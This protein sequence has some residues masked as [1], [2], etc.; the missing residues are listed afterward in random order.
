MDDDAPDIHPDDLQELEN[1]FAKV[2]RDEYEGYSV[3]LMMSRAM[4]RDM[5]ENWFSALMGVPEAVTQAFMEYAH[6]M[7]SIMEAVQDDDM[8]G[9]EYD[10]T[11]EL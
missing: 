6:I 8:D 11:D 9:Y 2:S 10:D 4:A 7:T 5:L 3:E 1:A